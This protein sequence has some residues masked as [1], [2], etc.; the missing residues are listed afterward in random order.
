MENNELEAIETLKKCLEEYQEQL[1][2]D[3]SLA[4]TLNSDFRKDWNADK[5]LAYYEK[6][7]VTED[8]LRGMILWEKHKHDAYSEE[9]K[10]KFM[11]GGKLEPN[12]IPANFN[13][14][15]TKLF[16]EMQPFPKE[17]FIKRLN[18]AVKKYRSYNNARYVFKFKGVYL[19]CSK[20][21]TH[22]TYS[23]IEDLWATLMKFTSAK[24]A[25]KQ[26]VKYIAKRMI[27]V[28]FFD[29]F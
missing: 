29:T 10:A 24:K 26:V 20:Y 6:R 5:L 8:Q 14:C 22:I 13:E 27:D 23:S 11:E 9:E 25:E 12:I 1:I 28:Q 4:H 15:L 17:R 21:A 2:V 19:Y 18:K 3:Y 16:P 7:E